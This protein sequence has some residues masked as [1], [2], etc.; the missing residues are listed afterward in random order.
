[1]TRAAAAA[2][3]LFKI[4]VGIFL[5][6]G[7]LDVEP[8]MP[9][10]AATRDPWDPIRG[11]LRHRAGTSGGAEVDLLRS[12]YREIDFGAFWVTPQALTEEGRRLV[13]QLSSEDL[14]GLVAAELRLLEIG[15]LMQQAFPPDGVTSPA[16]IAELEWALSRMA[17]RCATDLIHGRPEPPLPER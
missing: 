13:L 11:G 8:P 5:V 15:H 7:F 3:L 10:P 14:E 16:W 6:R 4:V 12:M 1:M 17:L 2:Y 9:P